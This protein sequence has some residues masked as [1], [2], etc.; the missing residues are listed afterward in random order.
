MNIKKS[1]VL[2]ED[3][4]FNDIKISIGMKTINDFFVNNNNY[5]YTFVKYSEFR[6]VKADY[7]ITWNVYSKFKRNTFYRKRVENFQTLN[8]NKLIIIELG[9]IKRNQYFSLGFN[10]IAD[11]GYYPTIPTNLDRLNKLNINIKELNYNNHRKKHILFC[12]QVPWDSQVQFID[13]QKWVVEKI[14][15]IKKYTNRKVLLRKHPKHRKKVNIFSSSFFEKNGIKINISNNNTLKNDFKN[16]YCVIAYNSTVLVDAILNG[17]PIIAG[18]SSSVVYDLATKDISK[19]KNLSK[20][21]K[22]DIINCLS[23]I[24]YKQWSAN[25][26]LSGLPFEY[27]LNSKVKKNE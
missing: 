19:I 2:Y 13:Y 7:A 4:R 12:T 23:K 18:S 15:K 9:F 25:E 8:N 3:R 10:G 5:I 11:F 1:I 17:I 21:T 27:L 22:E 16:C 6:L 26:I 14:K 24:S 20:Y